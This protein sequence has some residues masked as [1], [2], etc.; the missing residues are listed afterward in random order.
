[1]QSEKSL[2]WKVKRGRVFLGGEKDKQ[3]TSGK[4]PGGVNKSTSR[5]FTR[6]FLFFFGTFGD[7]DKGIRNPRPRGK[8]GGGAY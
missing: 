8:G 5:D 4:K 3:V 2:L 1:V 6:I 7:N